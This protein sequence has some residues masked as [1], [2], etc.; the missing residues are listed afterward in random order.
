MRQLIIIT[1]SWMISLPLLAQQEVILTK[2]TYNSLFFNPAYAGSHGLGEGT[3]LVH[4]R[5]Q[6]LGLPGAPSTILA[7]AEGSLADNRVGVGLGLARE[8]IGAEGRTEVNLNGAYRI[9]LDDGQIAGGIRAGFAHFSD[10]FGKLLVKDAGDVFDNADYSF[11]TFAVGVGA[12]Y[13]TDKFYMGLSVPTLAVISTAGRDAGDRVQ[14]VYAHAGLMIGNE[15]SDLKFEPSIL[16]K[17]Q[18]SVPLQATLGCNIWLSDDLAFGGHYRSSDALALS[19]EVHVGD[20]R[21]GA[22]Y[23][24]TLSEIRKY[25]DGSIEVFAGYRFNLRPNDP[26]IKNLRY[27]GRF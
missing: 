26:K 20:I 1:I 2:Y 24:F 10:D 25:S 3:A 4:Y 22:A 12:Y 21:F 15:Y 14:H 11:N 27:G 8:S 9:Q 23:D 7:A 5:N 16:V 13:N 17:Y 18:N 19:A 6:W